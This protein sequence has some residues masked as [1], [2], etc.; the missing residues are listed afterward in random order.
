MK[1]FF[2]R[3]KDHYA[4][5]TRLGI[6]LLVGQLGNIVLGFA[7]TLM[8]GRYDTLSLGAAAFVNNIYNL[9][10]IAFL[11]F[12]YGLTPLVSAFCAQHKKASAGAVLKNALVANALFGGAV[13]AVM[14]VLYFFLDRMGQPSELLPLIRPYYVIVWASMFFVVLFNVLRQLTDGVGDT[15]VSMW[16][17]LGGNVL[18]VLLNGLWIYGVGPFPEMGLAGAGLATLTARVVMGAGLAFLIFGRAKYRPYCRGFFAARILRSEV[19][20]VTRKSLPVALQMGMETAAFSLSAVMVGWMGTVELAS[21]QIMV[22]ISTL[23]FLFYYSIGAAMAIREAGYVGLGN[24][25][26]ARRCAFAGCHLLLGMM[27]V[28]DFVIGFL[29]QG[30]INLFTADADVRSCAGMLIF[31]MV[32]Y[33]FGD[34]MQICFANAV[35]GTA[36]VAALMLHAFVSFML[37]CLPV[38]YLFGFVCGWGIV[39]VYLAFSVGLFLAAALYFMSFMRIMSRHRP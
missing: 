25:V 1:T 27:L 16:L 14:G 17:I 18:N 24:W 20:M 8:V 23:G 35:R 15:T 22:T 2:L 32:L 26:G 4:G 11:G 3:Y 7:D 29:G 30:M 13:L 6:P 37:V 28:T 10:I 31:P 5:I 38:A 12:S 34:A 21:Y 39:G 19:G 9:V 33:Q 36:H